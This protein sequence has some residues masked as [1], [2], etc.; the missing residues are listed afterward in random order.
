MLEF[1]ILVILAVIMRGFVQQFNDKN[2]LK[3]VILATV[4]LTNVV[5]ANQG[6]QFLSDNSSSLPSV[7]QQS[8]NQANISPD[9]LSL[10]I[11]PVGQ[12]QNLVSYHADT[13][14]VPASTQKVI[15]TFIAL[16]TLGKDFTWQT[17]IYQQGLLW[18]GTLY[19]NIIIKGAGDPKL[20]YE[21]FN[22]LLSMVKV[23][24]IEQV[25][26]HVIIDNRL[27]SDVQFDPNAFDG[28]GLRPY[29]A[30]AN[31]LLINFGTIT[32]KTE[33]QLNAENQPPIFAITSTPTLANLDIP[34]QV[35]TENKPCPAKTKDWAV[36]W[37]PQALVFDEPLSVNC[38]DGEYWL[39]YPN[40]DDYIY[41]LVSAEWQKMMPNFQG[42]IVFPEQVTLPKK[43]HFW[44]T[45]SQ[46]KLLG[47]VNSDPLNEQIYDINHYSNN[48]MTEQV[49]LSLPIYADKQAVSNYPITF[50]FMK[51]WW[52]QHLPSSTPPMMTRASGLCRDCLIM[53]DSLADFLSF[54]YQHKDFETF[55]K[56]LSVAGETGTMQGLKYRQRNN[57]AIGRAWIKTGTLDDVTS[58]AGYVQGVSGQWYVVVGIINSDKVN[59]NPQAKAVLDT[60][61]GWTAEQ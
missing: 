5:F 59:H 26:G 1:A 21:K 20:S 24:G 49:A 44:R 55:K 31:G 42:K 11:R 9:S 3:W 45:K 52:Q 61:L 50:D 46:P 16:D 39:T 15:P 10:V 12:Q 48:V 56:S 13:P 57:V 58:M 36:S 38:Q 27:F 2:R 14:R 53:P 51:R 47:F 8:L 6:Y 19:G 23:M 60:M 29:N 32:I 41:R 7:I 37:Q 25:D 34:K 54:A 22:Q 30:S 43:W 17:K 35:A 18:R 28:Q 40:A 4:T 33:K